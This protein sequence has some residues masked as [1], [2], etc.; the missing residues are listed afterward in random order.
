MIICVAINHL[1]VVTGC[2][3]NCKCIH[4]IIGNPIL[5]TV[6]SYLSFQSTAWVYCVF[7]V[8]CTEEQL[9][10]GVCTS[11]KFEGLETMASV[12][13]LCL[14]QLEDRSSLVA[15]KIDL[16]NKQT[17]DALSHI[18]GGEFRDWRTLEKRDSDFQ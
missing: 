2:H 15:G 13:G 5:L 16:V 8:P 17:G 6:N 7:V 11:V 1:L 12:G 4:H 3:N 10:N 18:G 9:E 14:T